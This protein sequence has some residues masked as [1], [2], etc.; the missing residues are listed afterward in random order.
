MS[1]VVQP[2]PTLIKPAHIPDALIYDF[3]AYRDPEL[4][5]DPSQRIA[6]MVR[7]APPVFWTPRNGG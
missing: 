3:D 1:D 7:E 6:R 2:N 4:L 5:R